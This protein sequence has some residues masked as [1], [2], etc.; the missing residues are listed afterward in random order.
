MAYKSCVKNTC[1]TWNIQNRKVTSPEPPPFSVPNPQ[2]PES[3]PPSPRPPSNASP[4]LARIL[5][6]RASSVKVRQEGNKTNSVPN[7]ALLLMSPHSFQDSWLLLTIWRHFSC[8]FRG[9]ILAKL[10]ELVNIYNKVISA[11]V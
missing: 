9:E 4:A 7:L 10:Q 8:S 3:P 2:L 11:C 5:P 1:I 6:V